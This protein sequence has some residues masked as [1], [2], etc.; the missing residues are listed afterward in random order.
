MLKK[1]TQCIHFKSTNDDDAITVIIIVT[2]SL[3]ICLNIYFDNVFIFYYYDTSFPLIPNICYES[4]C[5]LVFQM[6]NIDYL[7]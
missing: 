2:V 6:S 3:V 1:I 4:F 7:Y 5:I